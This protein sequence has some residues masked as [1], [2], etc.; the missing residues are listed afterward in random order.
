MKNKSLIYF[1]IFLSI[2]IFIFRSLLLNYS[3]NLI[4]WRDYSYITWVIN[5]NIGHIKTLDFANIFNTNA[6]FPYKNTVFLSDTLFTQSLIGLPFSFLTKNPVAIFNLIFFTTFIFNYLSAYLLWK[7]IFKN[8][9]IGFVGSITTV[10]SPIFFTQIGHFQML[11]FWPTLLSIYILMKHRD[12]LDIKRL[13]LLGVLLLLQFL[14][15]VYI[16]VFLGVTLVLYFLIRLLSK[17]TIRPIENIVVI[18]LIFFFLGGVFIEGY[19]NTQK[20]FNAQRDYGEYIAY[21]AHLS[22]YIFPQQKG[23]LYQNRFFAKWLS[24][25]KHNIG[26]LAS[27]PG[28]A[29]SIGAFLGLV[30]IKN[31]K[32]NI[33]FNI[34]K[35][36]NSYLFLCLILVGFIF[37]LGPR[38]NFNGTF[39]GI[40]LP[41]TIF[42]NKIPI[43]EVIRGTSRWSFLLYI[44]LIYFFLR[45]LKYTKTIIKLFIVV[46]LIVEIIPL[47]IVSQRDSYITPQDHVLKSICSKSKTVILEIPVTHFDASGGIANGLSYITKRLLASEYNKC[48]LVNGYSGYDLPSIQK[49]MND[50]IISTKSKN[51][52]NFM[53][54]IIQTGANIIV[55]NENNLNSDLYSNLQEVVSKLENRKMLN[56]VGDGLY[57]VIY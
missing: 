19:F 57:Q 34:S 42:V 4:D 38:I 17:R 52:S 28:I 55:I 3:T 36:K 2:F 6:F 27:F 32:K 14:A 5:Q 8:S 7:T 1:L 23:I 30:Y 11:Y 13:F 29:L 50:L 51:T 24:Y 43:F 21:S 12:Y 33:S 47:S 25:N 20:Q 22:D 56:K 45:Y 46:I 16:S 39:S 48:N 18:F 54:T 9:F 26:E 44:G 40:P 41:Y 31:E 15:S 49:T 53:Q 35:S 37:S 10:F